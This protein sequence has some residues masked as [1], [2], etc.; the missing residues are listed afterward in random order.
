MLGS[1]LAAASFPSIAAEWL[2]AQGIGW[3]QQKATPPWK[4]HTGSLAAPLSDGSMLLIGGQAGRHG[5]ANF[6]CFNCTSEVWRFRHQTAE[7]ENLSEDVPWDPRWGHSVVTKADDT[8]WMF[9][10]CCE[11]GKPTVMLRDIWTFNPMTGAAWVKVNTE[12][13]FEGIQASSLALLGDDVWVVGGWSQ[14]RATLSQVV[15][16]DTVTLRWTVKSKH[17]E[18]PWDSRA[19]HAT[20]ISPDGKWLVMF[21]GQH[22]KDG[23]R[24]WNRCKDT[25][26]VPLPS[27]KAS[28]WEQ[29]GDLP[30]A[31]SSPAVFVLHTGWLMTIGGH[32]T[33][34][35]ELLAAKQEDRE[36]M[37]KHHEETRFDT[38]N[39][40]VAL[41]LNTASK[42]WRL[43]EKQAPWPS[44]DDCAAGVS[45]DGT[46][47]IFGGG[48]LYGGGGYH[49]DVWRLNGAAEKYKLAKHGG[50]D[51]L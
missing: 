34:D 21:G 25:W 17:G 13:P 48:T 20:A 35:K 4:P 12:P 16:L 28:E 32:W 41:D 44:R 19:D 30:A 40:V 8:V 3:E 27:A 2:D 5:G 31:R 10:G 29:I 49:Q 39:D 43:L 18:A 1:L 11:R 9:F 37:E 46:I 23:G 38:Y 22:A 6:D 42:T 33:P 15:V 51:E 50:G 36:G 26:R 7:W 45:S 14:H 47:L 24:F